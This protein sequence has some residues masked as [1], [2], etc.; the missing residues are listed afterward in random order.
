[1]LD[2][3]RKHGHQAQASPTP[4]PGT[5]AQVARDAIAE[6]ADL[7][8]AAG[9]DGTINEV[10]NGVIG[11]P[12][13]L[14]ILPG[15]TANVLATEMGLGRSLTR[16]ASRLADLT[17]HR[18]SV[19]R[20]TNA[21]GSRYFLLMAGI[22]LDAGIVYDLDL[23]LKARLGKLAYWLSGGRTFFRF[24]LTEFETTPGAR[25]TSFALLSRVRNYGGDFQIAPT[26]H[27]LDA[28]FEAV[29]FEGSHTLRYLGH[30][31]MLLSRRLGQAGGMTLT[32]GQSFAFEPLGGVAPHVQVDGEYA[33]RLPAKVEIVPDALTLLM[34]AKYTQRERG[35][36]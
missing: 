8:L 30:I 11:T 13:P 34:P 1:V 19:G 29:L 6:G 18:I 24:H 28:D 9:G 2:E 17:P 7:I 20:L 33:G 3:L 23:K 21:G 26:A 27:L 36:A 10:A 14:A 4:G 16:V 31:A 22:G 32:R 12:V 35:R 15:G 5:A 25:R